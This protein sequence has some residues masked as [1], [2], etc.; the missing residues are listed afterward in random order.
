MKLTVNGGLQID[1]S[2]EIF[3][4]ELNEGLMHQVV[5]A[6][7]AGG[8]QGTK[9]QK[10]RAEVS[11]GGA[12]PWKQKGTG[13]ARAGTT[14]GPLWRKG[15]V[16]FA[17]V[18]RD[19]TQKINKKVYRKGIK[20]ILSELVRQDR[21]LVTNDINL[22]TLKTRELVNYLKGLNLDQVLIV[23]AGEN[24]HLYLSARNIPNVAVCDY[25]QVDPVSLLSFEKVLFTVDALKKF[26]ESLK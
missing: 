3:A 5:T 4:C 13:R 1:V 9:A 20:I 10:T 23:S 25:T 6:Y 17:A 11:G 15:G 21:F 2:D 26:E 8:R 16:T 24:N 18:S 19:F 22:P 7:M 12:K 14:R